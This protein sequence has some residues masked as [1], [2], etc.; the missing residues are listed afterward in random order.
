MRRLLS[1]RFRLFLLIFVAV[2][3]APGTWVRTKVPPPDF[4][5][6]LLLTPLDS[7]IGFQAEGDAVIALTGAW[8]LES[9]N[10]HFGGYSA[11][12]TLPDGRLL[13][14][15]DRGRLLDMPMP[16]EAAPD[17]AVRFSFASG[18]GDQKF[19]ADLEALEIDADSGTVWAAYEVNGRLESFDLRAPTKGAR[20]ANI[21]AMKDWPSNGGAETMVRLAD[22]RFVILAETSTYN[23]RIGLLFAGDPI[24][25]PEPLKF[26]FKPPAGYSPVDGTLLP[27]GRVLIL[28]RRVDWGIPPR[29]AT[30]IVLADPAE[31]KAGRMWSGEVIARIG[32]LDLDENFE[33]IAAAEEADGS[34]TLYLIADDNLSAFQDTQMLRLNWT[35]KPDA[36]AKKARDNPEEELP[37]APL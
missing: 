13:T 12:I 36:D 6:P 19:N 18:E 11:L 32:A 34:V 33:G 3:L 4:S 37:D 2:G 24:T 5:A 20:T 22:G 26:R 15:S 9:R 31:I 27:D 17:V 7:P 29:F 35:P 21:D 30:A 10:A 25:A 16:Q 14:G 1:R 23:S 28:V 8:K